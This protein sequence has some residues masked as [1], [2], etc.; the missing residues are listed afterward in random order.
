M[1]T[2]SLVEA[3]ER[4]AR[5]AQAALDALTDDAVAEALGHAAR[6][7]GE[8]ASEVL[9]ANDAEKTKLQLARVIGLPLGQPFVLDTRLPELPS[10]DMTL[11]QAIDRAY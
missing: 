1:E 8:R 5:G 2:L 7:T 6:L 10:P 11:E 9:A 4:E 3:L